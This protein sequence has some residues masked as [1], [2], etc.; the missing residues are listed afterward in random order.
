MTSN[1]IEIEDMNEEDADD[2]E[3][4][5]WEGVVIETKT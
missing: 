1:E 5:L 3:E 4:T 2:W